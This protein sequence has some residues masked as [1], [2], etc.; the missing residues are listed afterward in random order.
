[1][2]KPAVDAPFDLAGKR[3]LVTGSAQRIG[4]AIALR[5]AREGAQV[6][7]HYSA[8][9]AEAEATAG[10]CAQLSKLPSLLLQAKLEHVAGIAK[11]FAAIESQWGGLDILVNNAARFTRRNVMN[12]TES[13][14]DEVHAVNLKA[15]FFCAQHA[16]R[17]MRNAGVP[18][19][20]VNMSSLGGLQA[21]AEHVHYNASKA[22]VIH[23]TRALA[24]AL[25]PDITVNSVAPGFI[26]FDD[27]DY[28]Q[29]NEG[30]VA[31][32]PVQ[33]PGRA[34]EIADAVVFFVRSANYITGQTLA[35]DGGL[36]I[37]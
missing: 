20:I 17:L 24:K 23:M 29:T 21:W 2:A 3:A 22:G 35:V 11:M 16:A 36:S 31:L 25:A 26:P 28:S 4:R 12:I 27:R 33:R 34:D 9:R 8:S 30:P 10:E 15:T 1:M 14:W 37:R 32:T 7:I 5:L 18:G 19:R 6:A 13:D